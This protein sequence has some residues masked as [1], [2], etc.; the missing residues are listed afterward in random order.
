MG[1]DAS[2][3]S[4]AGARLARAL[5]HLANSSGD[6]SPQ[7]ASSIQAAREHA[8]SEHALTETVLVC[9]AAFTKPVAVSVIMG[10]PDA[11]TLIA[12]GSKLAQN[13][14][15]A[16]VVA[17]QGP[18]HDCWAE[19][20]VVHTSDLPTDGRW[21]R[22]AGQLG[23]LPVCSAIAVPIERHGRRTGAL[24]VYSVY[25]DL[26][27]VAT[28]EVA[29]LLGVAVAGALHNTQ[30][31]HDLEAAA[32][33][34]EKALI[35]RSTIDQAKGIL[36]ARHRCD[37]EEAFRLLVDASSSANVKL[38]VLAERLVR[39]TADGAHEDGRAG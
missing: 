3:E 1:D 27:D 5:V 34:L 6:S 32:V 8:T 4:F 18:T 39:E 15:G 31:K 36:M 7:R 13:L 9:Q 30:V 16:Q 24:N 22:L 38:R 10:A 29:E 26:V 35:S 20:L 11:P 17:G 37:A 28:L 2:S 19:G 33:Q 14:D 21:P 23:E 12:T 25:D